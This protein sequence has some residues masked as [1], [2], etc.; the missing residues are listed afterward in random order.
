MCQFILNVQVEDM[1]AVP[2]SNLFVYVYVNDVAPL[3][4]SML[5]PDFYCWLRWIV[6]TN[7]LRI[8][9][10]ICSVTVKFERTVLQNAK[11]HV[12]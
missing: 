3:T 4:G 2:S 8:N 10:K 5:A 12:I 6:K 11:C 1:M 7:G 9:Q